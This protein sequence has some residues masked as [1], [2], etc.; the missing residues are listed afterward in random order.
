M[1][2]NDKLRMISPIGILMKPPCIFV[3][4]GAWLTL[5]MTRKIDSFRTREVLC[6]VMIF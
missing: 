6:L 3:Y 1:P 5:R 2:R 4:A